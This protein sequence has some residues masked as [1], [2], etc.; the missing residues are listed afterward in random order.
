MNRSH[1]PKCKHQLA[2]Y[3]NI[4]LFSYLFLLGK[5]R[6][7]KKKISIQY[8]TVEFV[9]AV[10]FVLAFYINF[11]SQ[12]IDSYLL[13]LDISFINLNFIVLMLRDWIVIS[14]MTI[15]FIYDLRWYLI[16]DKVMIPSVIVVLLINFYL[17]YFGGEPWRNLWNLSISAIIGGGFF[18][19]QF[20]I[21]R[22]K[23]IGGG[24][25]RFG[26]LMGLILGFP[27]ILVA[28]MLAYI[29]G[30]IIGVALI[31]VGK[32]K[33]SSQVPFGVFLATATIVSLFW[34]ENIIEWYWNL[35]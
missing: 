29:S 18:L 7:C 26:F 31:A 21:S 13:Y 1:C 10:L 23:W 6:Y 11:S 27:G 35:L 14:I 15:V 33:M 24:D 16:L 19:S 20:V 9:V 17:G 32:K 25:I 3:D 8:P 22:G 12:T 4:P 5:C 28:L 34:A 30:A 2:W